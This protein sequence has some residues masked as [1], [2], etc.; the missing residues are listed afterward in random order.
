MEQIW[1]NGTF[2]HC[3]TTISTYQP[4]KMPSIHFYIFYEK[5][6]FNPN[7]SPT[8]KTHKNCQKSKIKCYLSNPHTTY[9]ISS[10]YF[11]HQTFVPS[12]IGR[13]FYIHTPFF[14]HFQIWP[15]WPQK[16]KNSNLTD[17]F[18]THY[19]KP[20]MNQKSP[21]DRKPILILTM[22]L[23]YTYWWKRLPIGALIWLTL[24]WLIWAQIVRPASNHLKSLEEEDQTFGSGCIFQFN[25]H[26]FSKMTEGRKSQNVKKYLITNWSGKLALRISAV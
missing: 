10:I 14:L 7:F 3:F 26:T 23:L 9:Y 20:K 4:K 18:L 24:I 2:T 16:P 11:F 15:F 12:E 1:P 5:W 17:S 19:L 21:K 25:L 22:K 6:L 8:K 13:H